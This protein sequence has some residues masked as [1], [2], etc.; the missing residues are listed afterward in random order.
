MTSCS[1]SPHLLIFY[2][3]AAF[4][5]CGVGGVGFS[6]SNSTEEQ[7][8][9]KVPSGKPNSFRRSEDPGSSST[10]SSMVLICNSKALWFR[11][12][13]FNRFLRFGTSCFW[14]ASS[15]SALRRAIVSAS[16]AICNSIS[17][18]CGP[19]NTDL[20]YLSGQPLKTPKW[21]HY[22]VFFF[23]AFDKVPIFSTNICVFCRFFSDYMSVSDQASIPEIP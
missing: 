23:P 21:N 16:K 8:G 7:R 13:L 17:S 12:K 1:G 18:F 15:Y 14:A 6:A 3:W 5:A 9:L 2:Q 19:S 20:F 4:M 11:T 10:P 22:Q